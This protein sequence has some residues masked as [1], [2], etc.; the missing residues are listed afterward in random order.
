MIL[1]GFFVSCFVESGGNILWKQDNRL[2]KYFPVLS[3][4]NLNHFQEVI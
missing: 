2:T 3:Y 4:N 1:E